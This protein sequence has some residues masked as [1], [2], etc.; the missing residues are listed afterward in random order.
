MPQIKIIKEPLPLH[1]L[2]MANGPFI[3]VAGVLGASAVALGAYGA[4]KKYPKDKIDELKPIYQTANRMHFFHALAL[5]GVP[6]C[7][8]PKI[9]SVYLFVWFHL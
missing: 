2:V 4:H 3:R 9:V 5:L 7:K 6:L 8:N 1:E